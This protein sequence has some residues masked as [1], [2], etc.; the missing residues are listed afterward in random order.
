MWTDLR[1]GS[2]FQGRRQ[3]KTG[4][5]SMVDLSL[6]ASEHSSEEGKIIMVSL[7]K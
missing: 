6:K 4:K 2:P 7:I 1:R 3:K 5:V